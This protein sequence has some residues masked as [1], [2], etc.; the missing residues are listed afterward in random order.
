M[1]IGDIRLQYPREFEFI[2][3]LGAKRAESLKQ[4][5]ERKRKKVYCIIPRPNCPI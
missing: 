4:R 3:N 1:S 5:E 2:M